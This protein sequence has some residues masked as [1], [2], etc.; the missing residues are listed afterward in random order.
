MQA[1]AAPT[2]SFRSA[3]LGLYSLNRNAAGGHPTRIRVIG[4]TRGRGFTGGRDRGAPNE[5]RG[6]PK[7][8]I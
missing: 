6:A 5:I 4:A 3:H 8:I 2:E 7:E 1:G